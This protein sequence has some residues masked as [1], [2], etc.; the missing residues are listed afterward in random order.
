MVQSSRQAGLSA[1]YSELLDFDG[2]EIYTT[3][4][5]ELVGV[6]Y[7][8]AVMGY[9][10]SALIGLRYPDGRV[11]MNP[12]MDEV[13]A[14]GSRAVIIAEDDA[15][16][17]L[18]PCRRRRRR[19]RHPQAVDRPT[20]RRTRADHRWNRRGPMIAHELSRYVKAGSVLMI[21][22]DVPGLAEEIR[23]LPLGSKNL[24]VEARII[25]TSHAAS[26]EALEPLSWDSIMV[27]GYSDH[28]EAQSA[29]TRTLITLLHLRKLSERLG[30]HIS[31]VSENDR[32]TESGAGRSHRAPTT[33][34]CPNRLGQPE[35]A[36]ASE[37]EYRPPSSTTCWMR[38]ARNL[39]WRPVG[40]T[41]TWICP[42]A[43]TH[44]RSRPPSR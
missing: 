42:S 7:G 8:D 28:M 32:H 12:P 16:I 37:N 33:S 34:W 36:P 40:T 1:V 2:C 11:R 9:E 44:R 38:T 20:R 26:L 15:A 3:E 25:D 39:H 23:A 35:L 31:V 30:E 10:D 13:I 6:T 5:E 24:K 19:R 21:A 22:G 14:A 43:S 27:L 18:T 17:R 41:S 29:D 4:L